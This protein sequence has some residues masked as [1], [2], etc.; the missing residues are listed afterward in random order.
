MANTPALVALLVFAAALWPTAVLNDSDTWWHLSAGDWILSHRAVPHTDPFSWSLRGHPWTAHEWLSELL[1]SRAFALA[2]W[3]GVMLLTAL[4][5]GLT[6]FLLA[7]EAARSLSGLSLVLLVLGGAALFGPHLLA[8]PHML[9]APVMVLWFAD[10]GRH[11]RTP[12]WRVL[13]LMTLWANLHGSFIAGIVLTLPFA[14]E[15]TLAAADRPRTALAWVAFIAASLV[16]AVAT[17]FGLDGLMFPIRLLTM[18]GVDG[19]G[20]WSPVELFKP[21]PLTVAVAGLVCVWLMRRPRLPLIRGLILLIL[22]AASL[23]QQ[24]HEM[25]LGLLG[26]L[27]LAAPLGQALNQAPVAGK[28]SPVVPAAVVLL[29]GLRLVVPLAD[30][31]NARDPAAAIAHAPPLAGRGRVFNDY[32]FGG[33]L[34]RAGIAPYIDSRADMYGPV[35]LER[36]AALVNDP[37]A[38]KAELDRDAIG[39]T[40]LKPGSAAA[41]TLD[42]LPG[43]RKT[44]ADGLCVIHVR[45]VVPAR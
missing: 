15:G 44:Y 41:A 21:Q 27:L 7:R 37:K 45:A 33:Y 42:R 34:I 16:A 11:D 25:L 43:W 31:V 13:P 12:P 19:I 24:R 38:L 40:M 32:A 26:V 29:A 23:H 36:Y 20:E 9:A 2:G 6:V 35:F 28:V 18:P 10:L 5:A 4:A 8:R 14:L 1:M 22:L 3:P 30:P 39:W 17:P